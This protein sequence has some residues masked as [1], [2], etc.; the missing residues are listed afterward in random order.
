[1]A[2]RVTITP[3]SAEPDAPVRV[4]K[5]KLTNDRGDRAAEAT[6]LERAARPGIVPL[7][8]IAEPPPTEPFTIVTEH[9]GS[10]TLRTAR[11][12][13]LEAWRV[14]VDLADLMAELHRDGFVHGKLT[15]DHVIIGADRVWLCSPDGSC[16]DPDEDVDGLARCMR[17]LQQQWEIG[18]QE[19]PFGSQW[20]DLAERLADTTDPS[21]SATRALHSLRR[22][23]PR[24]DPGS[25]DG[26][27]ARS[28]TILDLLRRRTGV[29]ALSFA[30]AIA[31]GALPLVTEGSGRSSATGPRVEVD[32]VIYAIGVAG[33]DV[34][35]LDNPCDPS[36]PI[37]VLEADTQTVWAF[38]RIADGAAARPIAVIPGATDVRA[39]WIDTDPPCTVAVARGPAGTSLIET[40]PTR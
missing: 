17:D 20:A 24:G 1:M 34:A 2:T 35:L 18:G 19:V 11:L 7:V 28:T 3:T 9:V 4:A 27:S 30:I 40:G 32:G 36:T 33:D 15:A 39:E 21:R 12:G 25:A 26:S 23:E 13:P 5:V 6:W 10:R 31:V 22:L 16:D 14:M 38:D 8:A 37:I 29:L